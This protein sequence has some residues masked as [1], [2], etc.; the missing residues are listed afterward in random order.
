MGPFGTLM[1]CI[2][3]GFIT[4]KIVANF[5]LMITGQK[6]QLQFKP[7]TEVGRILAIGLV[8]FTG[9][10]TLFDHSIA[11]Q[12]MGNQPRPYLWMSLSLVMFWS[13]LLG[14]FVVQLALAYRVL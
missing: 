2:I 13:Y 1:L 10:A 7:Q 8:T 4:S 5:C 11:A 14:L 9:P 6:G 3:A 12:K